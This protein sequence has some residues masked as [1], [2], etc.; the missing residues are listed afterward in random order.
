MQ[1]VFSTKNEDRHAR[2][3]GVFTGVT[4]GEHLAV[5]VILGRWPFDGEQE[6]GHEEQEET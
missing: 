1:D 6:E 3:A 5:D 2:I 4:H